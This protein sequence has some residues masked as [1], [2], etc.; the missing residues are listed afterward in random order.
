MASPLQATDIRPVWDA[1]RPGVALVRQRNNA[2]W[3]EED[4]YA[5]CVGGQAH[6]WMNDEGDFCV[7][8]LQR[9]PF[10]LVLE[11]FVWVAFS[12]GDLN[13]HTMQIAAVARAAGAQR[14]VMT[15]ARRG[16]ERRPEWALLHSTFVMEI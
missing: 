6:L 8:Q 7:L 9:D 12:Q 3:R 13:S 11:C 14:L 10:T 1:I 2:S 5:A 4:V 15:S 16:W